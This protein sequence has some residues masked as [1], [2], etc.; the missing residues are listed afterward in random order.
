MQKWNK[1][2]KIKIILPAFTSFLVTINDF[3][4]IDSNH[5]FSQKWPFSNYFHFFVLIN[6][7]AR[8]I[9]PH[10]SV[11]RKINRI[12]RF[13]EHFKIGIETL[14][15]V[16]YFEKKWLNGIV[17]YS[18]VTHC[19]AKACRN[20]KKMLAHL[21]VLLISHFKQVKLLKELGKL[22]RIRTTE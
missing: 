1:M 11:T 15:R 18:F 19:L 6:S 22:D 5:L 7:S 16:W 17:L 21:G 13:F 8:A 10:Y 3:A 9:F 2:M 14:R 12:L 4:F 20:S